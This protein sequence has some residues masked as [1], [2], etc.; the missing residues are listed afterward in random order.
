MV[1]YQS[2]S[3]KPQVSEA[4]P[5]FSSVLLHRAEREQREREQLEREQRE[6]E[7][8]QRERELR[9]KELRERE[10]W[11]REQQLERERRERELREQE[12]RE[13]EL[14]EQRE[15]EL[16]EL[17]LREREAREQRE[18]ERLEFEEKMRVRE[19]QERL[20]LERIQREK[21]LLVKEERERVLREQQREKERLEFEQRIRE[22]REKLQ[23]VPASSVQSALAA[24]TTIVVNTADNTNTTSSPKPALALVDE[25]VVT[26]TISEIHEIRESREEIIENVETEYNQEEEEEV[27]DEDTSSQLSEEEIARRQFAGNYSSN[28]VLNALEKLSAEN[29]ST[30]KTN[31]FTPL[32][33]SDDLKHLV[34]ESNSADLSLLD[35][36]VY[37]VEKVFTFKKEISQSQTGIKQ[38]TL[39][40]II[41]NLAKET[42]NLDTSIASDSLSSPSLSRSESTSAYAPAYSLGIRL[43]RKENPL[44]IGNHLISHVE[45]NSLSERAGIKPNSRLLQ[46]NEITCEDK[47]H[48][49]VVFFLNYLL[50]K[51]SCEKVTLILEEPQYLPSKPRIEFVNETFRIENENL[52]AIIREVLL[53]SQEFN[54]KPVE[55]SFLSSS[56]F[57]TTDYSLNPRLTNLR[58]IIVEI[59]ELEKQKLIFV[60]NTTTP[61]PTSESTL[62]KS[63]SNASIYKSSSKYILPASSSPTPTTPTP[64]PAASNGI[65]NLKSIIL[66]ITQKNGGSMLMPYAEVDDQVPVRLEQEEQ[67]LPIQIA[68][69]TAH[70]DGLDNLRTIFREALN[71]HKDLALTNNYYLKMRGILIL[72]A[73][74]WIA[75]PLL[76]KQTLTSIFL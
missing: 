32:P 1:T 46:I 35:H 22:E 58:Q 9:D 6:R 37:Y 52:R 71:A 39:A 62:T 60:P 24:L 49:F 70:N 8:E 19:E 67:H 4:V 18:R 26:S 50:R 11:E 64:T 72:K 73:S 15:R 7:R 31:K 36:D 66:Q 16:R 48:E 29:S 17:E 75:K 12:Q 28:L 38:P 23:T 59:K 33:V 2:N 43:K 61:P 3:L 76:S 57:S 40:Q 47:T 53:N 44:E 74:T 27:E 68:S 56:S 14:R 65:D 20:E 10:Q 5:S 34:D 41:Q 21:E 13:R 30:L 42:A 63:S 25:T 45:A 51:T 69:P 55:Q 54:T